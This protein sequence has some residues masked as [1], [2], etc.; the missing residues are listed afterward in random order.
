MEWAEQGSLREGMKSF[1]QKQKV[2]ST[3]LHI[4]DLDK[5]DL[6]KL[7]DDSLV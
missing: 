7:G 5:V 3:F 1:S 6:V 4:T 2:L